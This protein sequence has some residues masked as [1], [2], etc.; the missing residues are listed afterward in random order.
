MCMRDSGSFPHTSS[1]SWKMDLILADNLEYS[2]RTLAFSNDK[3]QHKSCALM[4]KYINMYMAS[5]WK[6]IVRIQISDFLYDSLKE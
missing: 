1:Y 5:L 6:I 3:Y 2:K 4:F